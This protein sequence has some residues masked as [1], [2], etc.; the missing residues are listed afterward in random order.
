MFLSPYYGLAIEILTQAIQPDV[1]AGDAPEV[2][3]DEANRDPGSTADVSFWTS[4]EVREVIHSH[5]NFVVADTFE[6][7]AVGRLSD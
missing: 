5:V 3:R 1:T 4:R 6:M 7:G 2:P